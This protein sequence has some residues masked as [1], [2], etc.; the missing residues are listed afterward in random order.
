MARPTTAR[1]FKSA[2]AIRGLGGPLSAVVFVLAAT[3]LRI[4]LGG[5]LPGVTVFSLYYPAILGAA[6]VGIPP[7]FIAA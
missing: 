7:D 6:L 1:S 2:A 5:L 3:G 4:W